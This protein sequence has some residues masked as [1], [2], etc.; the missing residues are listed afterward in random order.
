MREHRLAVAT[1]AAALALIVIGGLVH[2]TGSS[3]ACPDWP[4]CNGQVFPR[5][6]GG[7]LFEYGHRIAALAVAVLTAVLAATV[8]RNR[9]DPVARRLALGAVALVGA[10]AA[11]GAIAVV[12]G[13]PL[14]ASVGHLA[15]SMAFLALAVTLAFRLGP[16]AAESAPGR[17]RALAGIA[18][19]GA[20]ASIVLGA[21][22][23][24]VGAS[25]ACRGA[26]LCDG[27]LWPGSGAARLHM[28]HRLW[29]WALAALVLAAA[30]RTL[31]DPEAPRRARILAAL[32]PVLL[33]GQGLLGIAT[34]RSEA[35]VPIVSLHLAVGAL[36]LADLVALYLSLGPRRTAAAPAADGRAGALAPA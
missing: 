36:V 34:V 6:A 33:A 26:V 13:L 20:Y 31:A 12:F 24:H 14:A 8:V 5:M 21:F 25:L 35:S 30:V 32:A 4:L 15:A 9:D 7:V 17:P 3:L 29:N 11:L 2:A 1:A 10:Q 16:A 23:R 22:V 18:A 27:S 19:A 28:A